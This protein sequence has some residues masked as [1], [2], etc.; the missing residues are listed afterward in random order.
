MSDQKLLDYIHFEQSRG[1][2]LTDIEKHLLSHGYTQEAIT[3]AF[4]EVRG[5]KTR[6]AFFPS[7]PSFEESR[8]KPIT[9]EHV[10]WIQLFSSPSQFFSTSQLYFRN[11]YFI[12][13]L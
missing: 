6:S 10:S 13:T 3:N 7:S 9:S 11:V 5:E 2:S 12:Y 8:E 1:F 4:L